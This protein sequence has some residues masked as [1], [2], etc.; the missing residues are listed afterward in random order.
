MCVLCVYWCYESHHMENEGKDRQQLRMYEHCMSTEMHS[1]EGSWW[2]RR[3]WWAISGSTTTVK[4]SDMTVQFIVWL[5]TR[6]LYMQSVFRSH[7]SE[8]ACHS[9]VDMGQTVLKSLKCI[10][11]LYYTVLDY[12]FLYLENV[13]CALDLSKS[14]SFTRQLPSQKCCL[15][16]TEQKRLLMYHDVLYMMYSCLLAW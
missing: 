7:A 2:W 4:T 14:G 13:G 3:L 15:I 1:D 8:L 16:L 12:N 9:L 11:I 10:T 6:A 5:H